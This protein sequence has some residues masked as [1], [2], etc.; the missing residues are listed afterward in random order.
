MLQ[1]CNFT[2]WW[3]YFLSWQRNI[4]YFYSYVKI[5]SEYFTIARISVLKVVILSFC[6]GFYCSGLILSTAAFQASDINIDLGITKAFFPRYLK[7]SDTALI[8]LHAKT[9]YQLDNDAGL[10]MHGLHSN[11][12]PLFFLE[13]RLITISIPQSVGACLAPLF[14]FL[15]FFLYLPL[16]H[17]L[18]H[19]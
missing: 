15:S 12:W 7:F 8:H 10:C 6:S 16:T 11:A 5:L 9:F 2:S 18:L 17:P 3:L 14:A 1:K 4:I 13:M 19:N